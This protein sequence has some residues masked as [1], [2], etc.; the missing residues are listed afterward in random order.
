M[1]IVADPNLPKEIFKVKVRPALL[2]QSVR[3]YLANQRQGTQSTKTRSEVAGTTKKVYRQKGTGGA[4]HGDRKAPIYVGGG[5]AFG[6]KPR[7]FSL[8]LSQKM[9][10]LALLGAL[11]LAAKDKKLQVVSGLEKVSGKTKD[12]AKFLK[13]FPNKSILIVVNGFQK[14]T[15]QSFRNIK[16]LTVLPYNQLNAYEVLKAKTIFLSDDINYEPNTH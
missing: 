15:F 11:S 8:K 6:P 12:A 13:D 5:I 9:R 2:A 7:D 1:K 3:V 4:R 14:N 10:H 16:N